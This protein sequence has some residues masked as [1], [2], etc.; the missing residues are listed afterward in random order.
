MYVSGNQC[1]WA[2]RGQSWASAPLSYYFPEELSWPKPAGSV[3][4]GL[5]RLGTSRRPA[6]FVV[7]GQTNTFDVAFDQ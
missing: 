7:F 6:G 4:F 5:W 3:A 2:L 1:S